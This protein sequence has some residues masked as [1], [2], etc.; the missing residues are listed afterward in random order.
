MKNNFF[1]FVL[2]FAFT[3]ITHAQLSDSAIPFQG[4]ARDYQGVAK[5]NKQVKLDVLIYNST[6]DSEILSKELLLDTD[7]YGVFSAL[8]PIKTHKIQSAIANNP[9]TVKLKITDLG[10]VGNPSSF[11]IEVSDELLQPVPYAVAAFNG[12]PTGAIMPFGGAAAPV[13]WLLCNGAQ[14]SSVTDPVLYAMFKDPVTSVAKTPDLR[15]EF[16]RGTGTSK[17]GLLTGPALNDTQEQATPEHN[18]DIT[19]DDVADHKHPFR[20]NEVNNGANT[21]L[22]HGLGGSGTHNDTS[23]LKFLSVSA[24]TPAVGDTGHLGYHNLPTGTVTGLSGAQTINGSS[25]NSGS[26][27]E[28][29]PHSYGVNYIIKR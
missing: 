27:T 28:V 19:V 5:I 4:I 15:G 26:G 22:Q 3:F 1:L 17:N 11:S 20:N 16:L 9:Y 7:K 25:A 18:H 24:A 10:E 13:G 12:V 21:I 6:D 29:R 23:L 14:I 8:I 2:F